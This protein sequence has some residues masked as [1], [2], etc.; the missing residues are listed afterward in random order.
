MSEEAG[1]ISSTDFEGPS[2]SF[3]HHSSNGAQRELAERLS[4]R[5]DVKNQNAIYEM[6]SA[7]AYI[8]GGLITVLVLFYWIFISSM[9]DDA[10]VGESLLFGLQ[11]SDVAMVIMF[12]VCCQHSYELTAESLDNSFLHWFRVL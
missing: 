10:S 12:W 3:S 7:K 8:G 5:M 11:F 9:N 6:I 2:E 4:Q 1:E